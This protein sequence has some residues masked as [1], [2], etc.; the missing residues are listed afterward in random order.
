MDLTKKITILL[1]GTLPLTAFS[2]TLTS[3]QAVESAIQHHPQ[4]RAAALEVDAKRIAERSA[5]AFENPEINVESPTGEFYAIGVL[6][7]FEFPTVYKNRKK[8]A[9]AE[10]QLALAG[11]KTTENDL[12][13]AV[14]TLFL[15]TQ[16]AIFQ[17][18][19]QRRRDSIFQTIREAATRQFA[20]GEIDLLQKTLA[21]NEAGTARQNHLVAQKQ[22]GNLREQLQ[23][24]TG[25]PTAST[26]APLLPDRSPTPDFSQNP[27][28]LLEKQGTIVAQRQTALAQS[29]N[30]PN[31]SLGY[32]NQGLKNTPYDYR[33][34]AAVGVPIWVGQNRATRESAQVAAR[35]AESRTAA[36][37]QNLA[38][39]NSGIQNTVANALAQIEYFEREAMPRSRSLIETA[40]RLRAAGQIDY[41]TFLRTLD[42]AFATENEYL[43]QIQMLN[44][45]QIRLRFLAGL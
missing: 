7:A 11:Q 24:L 44:A 12:R 38:A 22:A 34:R 8:V 16:V 4:V 2:Q 19:L 21:E 27:S 20:A 28:V 6:Q 39:E 40:T 45:A 36:A 17:L 37:E 26:L 9:Q 25:I 10:T 30:L 41:P 23:I 1:L 14:R 29:Q 3:E 33:F 5:R 15:E 13:F 35:A 18:N 42:T 31:F 43:A 32:L